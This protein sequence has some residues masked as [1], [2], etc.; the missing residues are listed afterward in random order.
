MMLRC[1]ENVLVISIVHE[2]CA[3]YKTLEYAV[4]VPVTSGVPQGTVLVGPVLFLIFINDLPDNIQNSIVH[5]FVDDCILNICRSVQV[6]N[7]CNKL[8]AD[9]NT[10][11]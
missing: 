11:E 7:D 1:T 9:L 8:Q 6:P 4:T 3:L 10:L 2:I 5:L